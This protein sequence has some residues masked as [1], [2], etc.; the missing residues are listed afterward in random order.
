V[1]RDIKRRD[2]I[3]PVF[4]A[5]SLIIF[6]KIG[7]LRRMQEGARYLLPS[8]LSPYE[9]QEL[10]TKLCNWQTLVQ[11]VREDDPLAGSHL[12][13]ESLLALLVGYYRLQRRWWV[14]NRGVLVDLRHWDYELARLVEQFLAA[15]SA[16]EKF[17]YWWAISFL[18]FSHHLQVSL[19]I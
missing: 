11:R 10:H 17:R 2:R 13:Y 18:C 14:G 4:I 9:K 3:K 1:Y 6:D 5:G 19:F 7:K 16:D 12:M 15:K 8:T